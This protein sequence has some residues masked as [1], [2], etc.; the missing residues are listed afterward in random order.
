MAVDEV[1]PEEQRTRF[2]RP[3]RDLLLVL[4]ALAVLFVSSLPVDKNTISGIERGLYRVIND[5]TL[6]PYAVVW[7]GMQLGNAVVVPITA[8]AA[9]IAR[10][11]RL[12]GALFVAGAIA[13]V[14][15]KVVK[16]IIQRGR[17]HTVL[18]DVVIRGPQPKGLGF[19]SGHAA[20]I[21]AL[22]VVAWPWLGRRARIAAA[23]AA[24]FVCFSR[25]YV[26]AHLPLDMVG[27]V[28]LGIA[29][30]ALIR[31]L[32]ARPASS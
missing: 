21:T 2:V 7:V 30:G 29:V 12:A 18:T 28:A 1:A 24:A 10:R 5:H 8:L 32:F 17:P 14:L 3:V 31:Y 26:G 4:G 13:Y 19:V 16:R 6:L 23:F 11:P 20:V 15:A 25:M 22:V 9:L 27:G